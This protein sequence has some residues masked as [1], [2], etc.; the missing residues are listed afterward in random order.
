MYLL[1]I[2]FNINFSYQFD[3]GYLNRIKFN[4]VTWLEQSFLEYNL[5][6]LAIIHSTG[7][8]NKKGKNVDLV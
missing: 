3:N 2:I 8:G 6:F 4:L 7:F 5:S 1:T